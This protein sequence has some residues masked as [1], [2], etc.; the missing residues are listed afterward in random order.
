MPVV[1]YNGTPLLTSEAI[2]SSHNLRDG[3]QV[4][5]A[6]VF[7]IISDNAA[8][9]SAEMKRQRAKGIDAP[10][11]AEIDWLTGRASLN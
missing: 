3:Q 2:L 10:A 6:K 1:Y 4:Q 7:E 9:F 8:E 5:G 11:C